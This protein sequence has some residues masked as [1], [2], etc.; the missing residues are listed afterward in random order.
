M[1]TNEDYEILKKVKV[2]EKLK[3]TKEDKT[4]MQLIKTQLEFEWRKYLIKTLDTI[5]KKYQK[6]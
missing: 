2:L 4:L 1:S 6:K 3:L 5:L